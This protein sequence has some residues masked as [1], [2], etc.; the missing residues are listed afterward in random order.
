MT[1]TAGKVRS[2]PLRPLHL[3]QTFALVSV[4]LCGFSPFTVESI[5]NDAPPIPTTALQKWGPNQVVVRIDG[6]FMVR[7]ERKIR[8]RFGTELY[9][10]KPGI[11]PLAEKV[12][13][14]QPGYMPLVAALGGTLVVPP[15]VRDPVT[16]HMV[17]NPVIEYEP[18]TSVIRSA[19]ATAVCIAKDAMGNTHASVQTI[20]VDAEL[21][22]RQAILKCAERDDVMEILS[23][24]DL[25]ADKAAGK[26]RGKIVRP[27]MGGYYL[28]AN[29]K[30]PVV[31]EAVRTYNNL[32]AK[33]RQTVCSKA[34]RLACDHNPVTRK[35]W[36]Y[37]EL[38]QD[39]R[40]KN[41]WEILQ[42]RVADGVRDGWEA[43]GPP[44]AEIEVASW[45]ES[46]GQA[47]LDEFVQALASQQHVEGVES[48]VV[49]SVVDAE[50]SEIDEEP[51]GDEPKMIAENP[52]PPQVIPPKPEPVPVVAATVVAPAVEKVTGDPRIP[53]LR[54]Q[55]LA[56][57]A[58][59]PPAET[60]FCRKESEFGNQD[61]SACTSVDLLRKFRAELEK[62]SK[63]VH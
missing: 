59:L 33:I 14:F 55:C 1:A 28:V 25:A 36:V 45:S 16:G 41:T 4:C 13:I 17:A 62:S 10:A 24:E 42:V 23:E 44:Y 38:L 9:A 15:A 30:S 12:A 22:F 58:D 29:M 52:I 2:E 54:E 27:F 8:L 26:L 47:A 35:T 5:V 46:R 34:E 32:G 11:P 31:V 48:V 3:F 49:G 20:V 51:D 37:G 43:L 40:E 60:E 39:V 56:F 50:V 6:G 18:G 61:V 7:A 63:A 57:M 19:K 53:K 21:Q